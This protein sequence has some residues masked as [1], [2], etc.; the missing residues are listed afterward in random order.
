[1]NASIRRISVRGAVFRENIKNILSLLSLT[2]L[3]E[4]TVPDP[5]DSQ[6][7]PYC[8]REIHPSIRQ[9]FFT[10]LSRAF[11]IVLIFTFRF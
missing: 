11:L 1:M 7:G 3:R 10:R 6:F 5:T 2:N 9:P 8:P 4:I